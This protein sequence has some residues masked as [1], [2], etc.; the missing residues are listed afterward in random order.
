[1]PLKNLSSSDYRPSLARRTW[2]EF[3]RHCVLFGEYFSQYVKMRMAY[4]GDFIVSTA[5]SL[6]ATIFG[7]CFVLVLFN[8]APSLAGWTKPEEIFLYGFSLLPAGIFNIVSLNMYDFGNNYIIE[9]KFDRVMLRPVSTL[10]QVLFEQ[11]RLESMQEIATG[12]F[13]IV[14][15]S[16]DL[17]LHWTAGRLLLLTFWGLC[18]G[19]IY[20]SVFLLL[21]TISFWFE[22]RVGVHPPVWNMINF[23]RYPLTIYS[24]A[25]QFFLCWIVPFGLASFYPSVRFLGRRATPEYLAFVPVVALAFFILSVS[26]WNFGT[27]HYSSTGS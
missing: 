21:T 20:I 5:T 6:A 11:F 15:A 4:R 8:K 2:H 14:W 10:F 13:C 27:R 3:S 1:M 7:L 9:G 22:D 12:L 26:M 23:G 19:V 25:V 16:R 17:H 24:G 18:A